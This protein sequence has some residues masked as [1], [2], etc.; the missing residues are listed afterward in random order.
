MRIGRVKNLWYY[1]RSRWSR[2]E[3]EDG[4]IRLKY[5]KKYHV[6]EYEGE[7]GVKRSFDSLQD[8][9][10]DSIF[11]V[12]QQFDREQRREVSISGKK[13]MSRFHGE[14]GVF[15]GGTINFGYRNVDKRWE[16][17]EDESKYVKKIFQMYL[18]GKSVK[19]IKVFLDSEGVKPRRSKTWNLHTILT[20]LKNRV[21]IGEFKWVDKESEE[22]CKI[23]LPQIISHSLFNRIQKKFGKNTKNKGNNLRKFNNLLGELLVCSC[24]QNITGRTR[25]KNQQRFY[26]CRSRDVSFLG[27][28][29]KP[30][31]NKRTMNMDNTDSL[32][33]NRIKEVVG[34]YLKRE[35]QERSIR[36]EIN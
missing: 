15:M 26:G 21:Y 22:E 33:F 27:K 13:Y 16:I 24:G 14:T 7:N 5:F 4:Y 23:V 29:V 11:T 1:S 19:D 30:C 9:V 6:D 20:M 36:R 2:N 35:I 3:Y 17:D 8:R 25:S 31:N 12:I 28:D 34:N 18:Q 32:V 10:M